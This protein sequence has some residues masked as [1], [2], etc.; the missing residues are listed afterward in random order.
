MKIDLNVQLLDIEGQPLK[1]EGDK[2]PTVGTAITQ[3]LLS[4]L[5]GDEALDGAKK[6]EMFNIWFDKVKD[7]KEADFK[8][9]EVV[10]IKERIGKAYHQLVVG[11][12][13]KILD[14]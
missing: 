9:E 1:G 2:I 14:K 5:K 13:F 12:M 7:K 4:P 3:S 8:A 6:A 11:Q 10:L